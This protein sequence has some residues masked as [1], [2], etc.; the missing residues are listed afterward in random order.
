MLWKHTDLFTES[1]PRRGASARLVISFFVTVGNYDYGFYWYLYLDGTIELEAKATGVV[2][3]S[4]Y[5]AGQPVRERGRARARRAVPPAPV[6]RPAGH[7]GRRRS[8]NA[9]DELDV[10]A[11]AGRRRTTPY[12]N[13]FTRTATRLTDESDAAATPTVGRHV[14]GQSTPS[15]RTG[16]ANRSATPCARR[17]SRCCSPID[18][19][20]DRVAG[21]RSPPG[22]SG[23]PRYDPDRALPGRRPASTSTAAAP[24]S[25]PG[26]APNAASTARTSCCGTRSASPTSRV[27]R[28]GRSCRSTAAASRSSRSASSTAT[29]P[30]TSRCSAH[31]APGHDLG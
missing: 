17:A 29:R 14:A 5:A 21:P 28:T 15:G 9:V 10:G 26:R 16:S 2:F 8:T 19:V 7:D 31:C 6:L 25:R 27:R 11:R 24:A 1:Q 13:A 20:V 30:S 22:T 23:S 4:A 12:G 18:V 3:T